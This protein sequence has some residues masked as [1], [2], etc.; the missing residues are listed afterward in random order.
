MKRINFY[1]L[2]SHVGTGVSIF[3][4]IGGAMWG[5]MMYLHYSFLTALAAAVIGLVPGLFML[6][7]TEALF[8]LLELLKENREQTRLLRDIAA[9]NS[10]NKQGEQPEILSDH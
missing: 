10:R 5:F 8:V 9:S 3:V 7:V 1:A 4:G 2:L 6:I